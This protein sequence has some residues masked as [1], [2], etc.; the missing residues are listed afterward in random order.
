MSPW[1]TIARGTGAV[2]IRRYQVRYRVAEGSPHLAVRGTLDGLLLA[3][4]AERLQA[5]L[6]GG[7]ESVWLVRR[8][9]VR[10]C[11][12]VS[13]TSG[14]LAH[15]LAAATATALAGALD[16]GT[17]G[18]S[19]VW[20]P[21]RAAFLARFLLDCAVGRAAGRWEYG[22]FDD[23]TVG[24]AS[25]TIRAV[26]AREPG[27]GL[28][29]LVR[30]TGPDLGRVLAQVDASDADAVLRTLGK[31]SASDAGNPAAL[32]VDALGRLLDRSELPREPRVAALALFLDVARL[33]GSRP[34]A[35]TEARAREVV[36]LARTLWAARP[37]ETRRLTGALADGAWHA[38]DAP[39]MNLLTELVAWPSAARR[40]AVRRLARARSGELEPSKGSRPPTLATDLGGM[41]L[42]LPLL[43]DLP[44]E[45]AAAEWPGLEGIDGFRLAQYLT[46]IGALGA[47]RNGAA[48]LDPALRLALDVPPK[49]DASTI[50]AWSLQ[51]RADAIRR[52][53]EVTVSCL[54]QLG[55]VS[56]AVT[57]AP[58]GDGVVAVDGARGFWLGTAPAAPTAIRDFVASIDAALGRPIA[59][60]GSEA[61]IESCLEPG[62]PLPDQIDGRLLAR[63]GE[64]A[65]HATVGVPFDLAP[66]MRELLLLA[67]Q[68][69]G[70]ELA[71][72]LPGF[73]RSTLPY[74][75]NNVLSFPAT[76]EVEP[77]RF[78]VR[79]GDPPLH[80]LLSLAGLN[81]QRFRLHATKDRE[82]V[83]TQQH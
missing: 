53:T 59:V 81:R 30:L 2:H 51:V 16:R 49:I 79:V 23:I 28:D 14:R 31:V 77:A 75:W 40:E 26:I 19:V 63:L 15:A 9:D 34:P 82:W 24:S 43:D 65:R 36:Q 73:S 22:E 60:T 71:W 25:S 10:T 41:F 3:S 38:V 27:T 78:V 56:G 52:S 13:W 50:S 37:H 72:R 32:V 61:W 18:D 69:L 67:A 44:W 21:D 1:P 12:G 5:A 76:V 11:V 33:G 20:F 58:A 54:H 74:L 46:V 35:R 66:P 4:L 42:L 17:D 6:P 70:R 8:L 80:L 47:A 62:R 29:A 48:V 83:L 39:A 45:A 55:K 64:Q 7:D 68:A 57:L